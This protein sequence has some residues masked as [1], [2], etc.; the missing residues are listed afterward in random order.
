MKTPS[1]SVLV[2]ALVGLFAVAALVLWAPWM[3]KDSLPKIVEGR[4]ASAWRG[5]VD[6]C[7][8]DCEGCGVVSAQRVTLGAWVELEYACGMLPADL[9]EYH[10]R[11]RLFL[12]V[13]GTLHGMP[14]P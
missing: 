12:S 6:G 5:V 13:L 2:Y 4:F 1:P 10:Q 11:A 3:S 8:L 7:G 9:P 14:A